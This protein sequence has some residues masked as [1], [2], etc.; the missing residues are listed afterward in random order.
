LFYN[1]VGGLISKAPLLEQDVTVLLAP[2][3]LLLPDPN[4]I[5]PVLK[6][7]CEMIPNVQ[8]EG[9]YEDIEKGIYSYPS[10][11]FSF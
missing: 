10:S 9:V 5:L 11:S 6:V 2:T 8:L 1:I 4:S 7:L 3:S